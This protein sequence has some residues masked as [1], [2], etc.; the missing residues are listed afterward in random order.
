MKLLIALLTA[1]TGILHLLV[2]FGLFPRSEDM[3]PLL[4]AN[5]VGYLILLALFFTSSG[6][7]R[8]TIRW[9]LLLYTLITLVGYFVIGYFQGQ[10]FLDGG[11]IPLVIKA[12]ELLLVILLFLDRGSDRAV[13]PA[14]AP[15]TTRMGTGYVSPTSIGSG[16]AAAAAG[17]AAAL[18]DRSVVAANEALAT[19]EDMVASTAEIAGDAVDYVGD[20]VDDAWDA[21]TDTVAD[22]ADY[23]GDKTE[24]AWDT[25]TDAV[26][27]AATSF[28]D[29]V[30]DAWDATADT[31]TDAVD[32]VGD[33]TEAAWDATTDA[34]D[35]AATSVGNEVG[36]AWDATADTAADAVDYVG[37]KTEAAWDATTDT[38]DDAVTSVGDEVGDAWDTSVDTVERAADYVS[39]RAEGLAAAGGAAAAHMSEEA[40]EAQDAVDDMVRDTAGMT[41]DMDDMA[42]GEAESPG[43]VV[44][45]ATRWVGETAEEMESAEPSVD[46]LRAELEDYL[47]SFGPTSEFRKP[48]EYIEGIGEAFGQKLRAI[49]IDTVLDLIVHGAT[50]RGRKDL[51][52]QSGIASSLILTWVNHVD[53]FRV[54]GIAQQY[55]EL[56]EESG[57][58]TVVELAQRNPA[59]LHKRMNDLNEQRGLVRRTPHLSEVENWVQQAK[60]LRRLIHY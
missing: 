13:A 6:S 2:G 22:T 34:V 12:I 4:I 32:Y 30:G 26:D 44:D 55:A 35:D 15:S 19:T 47:L 17:G 43:Y 1:A 11:T 48:I 23:V 46:D 56:L 54:K 42:I 25:T 27:D 59:N 52:T 7:R 8:G 31:A 37:D 49:G 14:M 36:D 51:S 20:R 9:I 57:V 28:G 24:A 10:G 45:D 41:A 50:R 33:K 58:D 38:V 21:T 53:L 40:G 60:G 39:D 29:E 5:G 16:T 3:F 18:G